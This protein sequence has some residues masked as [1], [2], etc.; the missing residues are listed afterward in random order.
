MFL[1]Y[2]VTAFIQLESSKVGNIYKK[3]KLSKFPHQ[4]IIILMDNNIHNL[5]VYR[6]IYQYIATYNQLAKNK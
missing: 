4:V 2:N 6:S 1:E 3:V 5:Y